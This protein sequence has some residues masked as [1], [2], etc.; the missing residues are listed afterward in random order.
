MINTNEAVSVSRAFRNVVSAYPSHVAIEYGKQITY[1]ELDMASDRVMS[2]MVKRGIT[3]GTGV[4]LY[5]ADPVQFIE[6]VIGVVKLGA[7]YIPFDDKIPVG[8]IRQMLE[9]SSA[10]FL[11][12]DTP[13]PFGDL[14]NCR[15]ID[16]GQDEIKGDQEV[17]GVQ[18]TSTGPE[19][20]LYIMFTSGSTGLP[21]GVIIPNRGVLR[22][23]CRPDYVTIGTDDIFLQHSS[24]SFDAST[25]EI[26]GALLNG[27][28]LALLPENADLAALVDAI[29]FNR[30][31]ILFLTTRFFDLLVDK[32]LA[33]LSPVR[34]LLFGGERAS[35][36][37]V[38]KAFRGLTGTTLLNVYGPTENTTFSTT[39]RVDEQDAGRKHIPIGFPVNATQAWV[40]D[41]D[42]LGIKA[43]GEEGMLFLGG[44]G[45]A[46]GYTDE[47]LTAARFV[48]H[49]VTGS[50]LYNTGDIVVNHKDAGLE[51][52]GRRDRQVKIR[53]HR[54]E[55]FEIETHLLQYPGISGAVV[56]VI[57]AEER[58]A[59]L[60]F[61]TAA[62]GEK[63]DTRLLREYLASLLPEAGIPSHFEFTEAFPLT[64]NGKTDL[65]AL[66]AKFNS[67]F[68]D[69][70]NNL[71]TPK[72]YLRAVWQALLPHQAICDD[73][74][75]FR[76]GG[77]SLMS[78]SMIYE[79]Q[80]RFNIRLSSD[81]LVQWPTFGEFASNLFAG[82]RNSILVC[83]RKGDGRPPL[84][85]IPFKDGTP[86]TYIHLA[87]NLTGN[88]PVYSFSMIDAGFN[89]IR[90]RS[91]E[92][93]AATFCREILGMKISGAVHLCGFSFG[94]TIA[95]EIARQLKTA[96]MEVGRVH[97]LDA[98][99]ALD[100]IW[101][102]EISLLQKIWLP[103]KLSYYMKDPRILLKE[104]RTAFRIGNW[105][106]PEEK[107]LVE[108][109]GF[110][111]NAAPDVVSL[112]REYRPEADDT[113]K[114]TLYRTGAFE[115]WKRTRY[116][117]WEKYCRDIESVD[118][119]GAH[120]DFLNPPQVGR[121]AQ[122]L[123]QY[124]R[125]DDTEI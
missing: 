41:E 57:N 14:T 34:Q 121:L 125:H 5:I 68:R 52:I 122:L 10:G 15:L 108:N 12:T 55:L 64:P 124:L 112:Y 31:T 85:C 120:H 75:F 79:I 54:F 96:G 84:F 103:F 82:H 110:F 81:Y 89:P 60:A 72:E 26:W 116:F 118:F 78:L 8:R 39:H 73:T 40:M 49:P 63:I 119:G 100:F 101:A 107:H 51:Y 117:G 61:Y 53:G 28:R 6:Y 91:V 20:P 42:T 27:A 43:N 35:P 23:V 77:D 98:P 7:I 66:T 87:N 92:E 113:L 114:I 29:R 17:S 47:A 67:Q 25:F 86:Y 13:L 1:H 3:R 24:R 105:R 93:L 95:W 22:L 4:G 106:Q 38:I 76:D 65:A 104:I 36:S 80:E 2:H 9:S 58:P 48:T 46:L 59:L 50:R 90:Y 11:V 123:D 99:V 70:Q 19:D 71:T 32:N 83:L 30:C 44:D 21:K 94:G 97:L 37:H 45:L 111:R 74:S 56:T 102:Q 18:E 16:P 88:F 109:S 62:G 69:S 33:A 115:Y